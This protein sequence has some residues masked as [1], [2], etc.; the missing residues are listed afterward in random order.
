[1][2][3]PGSVAIPNLVVLKG[4]LS[5]RAAVGVTETKVGESQK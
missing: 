3:S 5:V 4:P 2:G 1:M